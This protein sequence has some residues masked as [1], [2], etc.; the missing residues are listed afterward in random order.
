MTVTLDVTTSTLSLSTTTGVYASYMARLLFADNELVFVGFSFEGPSSSITL[1]TDG[2]EYPVSKGA[3]I[4]FRSLSPISGLW[5]SP[6][7]IKFPVAG[8]YTITIHV[9]RVD[10]TGADIIDESTPYTVSVV[11]GIIE[12]LSNGQN[13]SWTPILVGIGAVAVAGVVVYYFF[14]RKKHRKQQ[15]S[16]IEPTQYPLS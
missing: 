5:D 7:Q 8:N 10:E 13:F 2:V 6:F 14:F 15:S 16:P 4:L 1:K 12:G 9:G 11:Q 3:L